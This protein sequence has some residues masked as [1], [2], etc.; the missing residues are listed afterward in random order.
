MA[1]AATGTPAAPG[2]VATPPGTGPAQQTTP[3]T[4]GQPGY[5][6][7]GGAPAYGQPGYGAPAYGIQPGPITQ[8]SANTNFLQNNTNFLQG[9]QP[10]IYSNTLPGQVAPYSNSPTPMNR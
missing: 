4:P 10:R 5:V 6:P 9:Q 7:L 8:P 1:P 3:L 2:T